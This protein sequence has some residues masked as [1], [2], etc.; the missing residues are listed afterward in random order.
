MIQAPASRCDFPL[1]ARLYL[2]ESWA[3]DQE[4]RQRGHIPQEVTLASKPTL[5]LQLLERAQA[6]G[7]PFATVVTDSGVWHS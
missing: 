1:S 7:V 6:W 5:A 2:S 3:E 4:R